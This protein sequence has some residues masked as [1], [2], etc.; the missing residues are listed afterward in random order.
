MWDVVGPEMPSRIAEWQAVLAHFGQMGYNAD[1][2]DPGD[3][4][5]GMLASLGKKA[6]YTDATS[7]ARAKRRSGSVR[8]RRLDYRVY[9]QDGSE[10]L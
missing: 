4:L 8:T 6:F 3:V 9:P 1:P 2:Y 10:A 5:Q 7:W